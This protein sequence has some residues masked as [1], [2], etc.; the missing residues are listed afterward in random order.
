MAKI[1]YE[2]DYYA[3]LELPATADVA[4]IKKQ[5]KKLALKYH[6]DRNPGR[7]D[8]V[9][10]KFVVIQAAHEILTDP[11]QKAKVDSHRKRPGSRFPASS[12]VK[13]NPY[14][15]LAKDMAE[16]YGAPPTRRN[17]QSGPSAART[18]AGTSRY[19]NWGVPPTAKQKMADATDNLRAWD[20]MRTASGKGNQSSGS[21]PASPY[22]RTDNTKPQP[23]PP[24]PRTAA[25]ARRQ[26]A[27]FGS[28]TKKSGYAPKSPIGGDEPPVTKNGYTNMHSRMSDETPANTRK[29]RP[30]SS[31]MDPL[32]T[33]FGEHYSDD[34]Q[35]TPYASHIGEKT[36]PFEGVGVNRARSA[37]ETFR[38]FSDDNDTPPPRPQRQRSASVDESDRFKKPNEK[39]ASSGASSPSTRQQSRASARYSPHTTSAPSTATFPPSN[40]ANTP[41][42]APAG[43]GNAATS[44]PKNGPTVYDDP[45]STPSNMAFS[46]HSFI[47]NPG[48]E[49]SSHVDTSR[50]NPEETKASGTA[51]PSGDRSPGRG[52]NSFEKSL[53]AQL[54]QLLGKLKMHKQPASGRDGALSPK[55]TGHRVT[56]RTNANQPSSFTVPI[57]EDT[58]GS[59]TRFM[60][61]STDNINTRF[62]SEEAEGE[63]FM[64]NAGG[65]ESPD[66][67]RAKRS[68]SAPRGRR[69][70]QR[71]RTGSS[72]D[73][74]NPPRQPE[75]P[76]RPPKV[77]DPDQWEGG[78]EPHHFVPPPV[79][80]PST[81]PTRT[82]RGAKK[83]RLPVRQTAGTAGLV[84]DEGSS[85]EERTRPNTAA[86]GFV[87]PAGSPNAMDIDSPPPEPVIPPVLGARTINVEPTKPEWRAGDV[88]GVKQGETAKMSNGVNGPKVPDLNKA[89]SEDT[90]DF[91]RRDL[92]ADFKK[93][94][95]FAPPKPGLGSLNDL[96]SNLPFESKAA[97][98]PP[99]EKEKPKPQDRLFPSPPIAPRP[100][101]V[102]GVSTL[103]P[104]KQSWHNYTQ[105]F[106]QYLYEWSVFNNKILD[107]FQ[108]RRKTV[109]EQTFRWATRGDNSGLQAYLVGLEED[110]GIRQ[111]WV[112]ATDAHELH[113]REFSKALERMNS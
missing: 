79:P 7:E 84:D 41:T 94:E 28:P 88:N 92:F 19:S 20:R 62:V 22:S 109:E 81:S 57:D 23:P 107:H 100:P 72:T 103:K 3:D 52:L 82:N 64:F 76:P 5:F 85:S 43:N 50:C 39:T 93:V 69:S 9:K 35:R 105:S 68:K 80:K 78:F 73:S 98:K 26:E 99:V 61:N 60:R 13:G 56:K 71:T 48:D 24:P 4:E 47:T 15:D 86:D 106:A 1:D 29:S 11:A 63:S 87:K 21:T 97:A 75:A 42:N 112:A 111:K 34:R 6:P 27:A 53:H 31:H 49:G 46:R 102:L 33:Q 77:F 83:G 12:G 91:I 51:T 108:A 36:N 45:F 110:R 95:P 37:R 104:S 101:T 89:G 44:K 113:V 32:S 59:A 25:Q 38:G 17:A 30:S 14:Q 65:G 10:D 40:N 96:A 70:P 2:R 90:P 66:A 54:Q 67:L 8:V 58:F 16:R 74:M 18:T 55:K